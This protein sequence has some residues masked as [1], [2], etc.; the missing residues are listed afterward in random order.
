MPVQLSKS[1]VFF[2]AAKS[3]LTFDQIKPSDLS[4]LSGWF[5][6]CDGCLL[7][8]EYLAMGDLGLK[9]LE[10]LQEKGFTG[11]FNVDTFITE[12][13]GWHADNI[14]RDIAQKTGIELEAAKI[15]AAH[16][17]SVVETLARDVKTFD[18]MNDVLTLITAG[19]GG[20]TAVVTSS[21][22]GRVQPG[23]EKN[24]I[25]HHF[26]A[27]G[28]THIYSGPDVMNRLL[29]A[30]A[31]SPFKLKPAPDIYLHAA[32]E[33]GLDI[34]DTGTFEDSFSGAKSAVAAGVGYIIGFV[35]GS[36][37]PHNGKAEH[38][39][40][41]LDI[42]VHRVIRDVREMPA[43]L[44]DIQRDRQAALKLTPAQQRLAL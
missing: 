37:I 15:V 40:K 38:A 28:I 25:S 12:Y 4:F 42:G 39:Q 8:S 17:L 44:V 14:T 20:R 11:D 16:K 34:K 36:H 27:D 13:A 29:A 22:I 35:G 19:A 6:D 33:M 1:G 43:A 5:N 31:N 41:L 3:G 23:L 32:K 10:G 7:D 21:E 9:M 26:V 18:G 30:D 24:G 2:D